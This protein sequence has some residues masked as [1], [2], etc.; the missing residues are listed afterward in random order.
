VYR[1]ILE[2]LLDG[3]LNGEL[4]S[5]QEELDHILRSYPG[6]FNSLPEGRIPVPA[7]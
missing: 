3:R 4:Q 5:R 6:I 2:E 1:R 7:E